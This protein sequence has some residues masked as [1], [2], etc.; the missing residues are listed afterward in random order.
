[1]LVELSYLFFSLLLVIYCV[2]R[3]FSRKE[4]SMLYF[5]LCF[6]FLAFSVLFQ[7]VVSLGNV[8]GTQSLVIVR[9]VELTGLAFYACFAIIF[10]V[11]LREI[12][13]T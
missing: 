8:Y 9:I 10:I 11:G 7:A 4:R 1:M 2:W 5:A 12:S 6:V 3:F 13:K